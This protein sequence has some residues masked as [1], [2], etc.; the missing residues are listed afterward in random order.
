MKKHQTR[1]GNVRDIMTE[2]PSCC[3]PETSLQD[4]AKNMCDNNCGE[5][6]VLDDENRPIGVITDR[7][8]ACRAVAQGKNPLEL[9]AED[10][11][12]SPCVTVNLDS[13]LDQC[14]ALMEEHQI[15][16]IPVVDEDGCCCGIVSQAD[17]ALKAPK[18]KTA[19]VL[20]EVSKND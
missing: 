17:I 18:E 16:R 19:E 10:C 5:I 20:Q 7:D 3:S 2:N 8:I 12:S 15:R 9:T 13:S 4:V 14:C 1:K 11:M 6:P